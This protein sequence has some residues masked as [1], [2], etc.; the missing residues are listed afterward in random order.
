MD[1]TYS[2]LQK[3]PNLERK[4]IQA[5]QHLKDM[6]A[7]DKL[8]FIFLISP[9]NNIPRSLSDAEAMFLFDIGGESFYNSIG[10]RTEKNKKLES[11]RNSGFS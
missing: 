4:Y 5:K 7:N 11:R 2:E 1:Y 9:N 3:D 10:I 8:P 6:H